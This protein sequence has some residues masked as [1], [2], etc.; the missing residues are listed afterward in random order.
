MSGV[1]GKRAWLLGTALGRH[2]A[3]TAP[4]RVCEKTL[5]TVPAPLVSH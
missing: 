4:F 2:K 1:E 3:L 5:G